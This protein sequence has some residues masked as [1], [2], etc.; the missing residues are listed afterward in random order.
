MV[1]P[2]F[3]V[4]V[5]RAGVHKGEAWSTDDLDEIVDNFKKLDGASPVRLKLGHD[6]KQVLDEPLGIVA[7]LWRSGL[8]LRATLR[9]VPQRLYEL[10]QKGRYRRCSAEIYPRFERSTA[11]RQLQGAVS[12]KVMTALALLG[13]DIPEVK[14]MGDLVSPMR[15]RD[16]DLVLCMSE[17][18]L[19]LEEEPMM[20]PATFA[21][22]RHEVRRFI[23]GHPELYNGGESVGFTTDPQVAEYEFLMAAVRDACHSAARDVAARFHLDM[24][25]REDYAESYRIL[26]EEDPSW[27]AASF[28]E[29]SA[30]AQDRVLRSARQKMKVHTH[31]SH[32]GRP[33]VLGY[34]PAMLDQHHQARAEEMVHQAKK[35]G[36]DLT[37]HDGRRAAYQHAIDERP[38]LKIPQGRGRTN[39]TDLRHPGILPV[40]GG[41]MDD[42][43]GGGPSY[44]L[45]RGQPPTGEPVGPPGTNPYGAV[46]PFKPTPHSEQPEWRDYRRPSGPPPAGGTSGTGGI[47]GH[48][49]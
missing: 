27:S 28:D 49:Y 47:G 4:D 38:H 26:A 18:A 35:H 40:A 10:M 36:L 12:G 15:A 46:R 24:R 22:S 21:E 9:D 16:G 2:D 48:S 31:G 32:Y 11:G 42:Q 34:R 29:L 23:E 1:A 13:A 30:S 45:R 7:A 14:D 20:N 6:D 25:Q 17:T 37:T 5:F 8:K 3:D 44:T 39:A 33:A 43:F 41:K 19:R